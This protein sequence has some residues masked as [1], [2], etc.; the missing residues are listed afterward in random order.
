M[1]DD[2]V[3]DHSQRRARLLARP[4]D[5]CVTFP[6]DRMDM[7]PEGR[8]ALI[9]SALA[10]EAFIICHDTLG[11]DQP[12]AICR[13]FWNLFKKRTIALRCLEDRYLEI[14]PPVTS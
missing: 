11:P 12:R 10:A 1:P 6:D 2:T 13:G 7:G 9:N 4:C 5:T 3:I 8:L 14:D